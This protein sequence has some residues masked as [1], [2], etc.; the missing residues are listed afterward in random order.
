[1]SHS[2][3]NI[4]YHE[5]DRAQRLLNIFEDSG[6]QLNVS[7]VHS[8]DHV[9]AWHKHEIQTDYWVCLKGAFKVGLAIPQEDGT[10]EVKWEYISDK[11]F[12][13]LKIPTGIYHGYKAVEQDSILLYHLTHKYNPEDEHRASVGSFGEDWGTENK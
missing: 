13:V 9:V 3:K 6:G 10:Y 8:S 4:Q 12:S 7:Y 5:D 2:F 1:M 11:N